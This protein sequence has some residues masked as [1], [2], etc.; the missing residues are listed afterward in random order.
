VINVQLLEKLGGIEGQGLYID[1][2]GSYMIERVEE[3]AKGFCNYCKETFNYNEYIVDDIL[4]NIFYYRVSGYI[5]QIAL[6]NML[7]VFLKK[8]DKIRI[9]VLDSITF[10]FRQG[11][12]DYGLRSRLLHNMAKK[13]SDIAY[14]FNIAIVLMN[15]VTTK[16][17]ITDKKKSYLAPALG[18]SWGPT[19]S[20]RIFLYWKNEKRNAYLYKSSSMKSWTISYEIISDGFRGISSKRKRDND[21]NDD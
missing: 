18:E 9:I 1:T 3:I 8:H 20:N 19:S 2:E 16:F 13:L 6:I 15:Q 4:K 7:P 14:N 17:S 21:E 11:F 5:E 10:H 12:E